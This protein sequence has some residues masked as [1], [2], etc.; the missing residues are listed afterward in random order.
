MSLARVLRAAFSRALLQHRP[1]STTP[2]AAGLE[3]FFDTPVK[4]GEKVTAGRAWEAADLRLKSWDDL[5][6]LWYVLLKERNMLKSEKDNY[7]AKGL[8]MPNGRRQ[9]KVR[10]SMCR[11]KYVM[12]ERAR[13]E[14]DPVKSEQLKRFVNNL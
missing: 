2:R 8:V 5:H 12:Y 9:T 10:K 13:A 7:K 1:L 6:K 4:E 14:T 11:I 3:D